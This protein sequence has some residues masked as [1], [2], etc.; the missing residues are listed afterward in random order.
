[1]KSVLKYFLVLLGIGGFLI[2][3]Q[4]HYSKSKADNT[5]NLSGLG[6]DSSKIEVIYFHNKQRCANCVAVEQESTDIITAMDSSMI[7]FYTYAIGEKENQKL[8]DTLKIAG[9]TLLL[10][11]EDKSINLTTS[12]YLFARIKPE[13]FR[14]DLKSAIHDLE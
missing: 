12:A 14:E 4:P 10:F 3:C 13:K 11:K 7:S 8:E 9:P 5:M 1:M 2:A 6:F